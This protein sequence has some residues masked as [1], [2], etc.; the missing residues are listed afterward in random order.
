[1][2][3]KRNCAVVAIALAQC[4]AFASEGKRRPPTY[5]LC[6][7]ANGEIVC[8]PDPGAQWLPGSTPKPQ[9][10]P[11]P[12][13]PQRMLSRGLTGWV[14][15]KYTVTEAGVV[16]GLR[17]VESSPPGVFDDAALRTV[18][19]FRYE[20]PTERGKAVAVDGIAVRVV[21]A[22][23]ERGRSVGE[24]SAASVTAQFLP[25]DQPAQRFAT[26]AD[27]IPSEMPRP[28]LAHDGD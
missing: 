27:S 22:V 24:A 8:E 21:Y 11:R 23:D 28:R 19:R 10:L 14:Y 5:L 16:R 17:V 2:D 15:A 13:Y 7:M 25:I 6:G 9:R 1:M 3:I 18:R 20:R 26:S 12:E 4:G